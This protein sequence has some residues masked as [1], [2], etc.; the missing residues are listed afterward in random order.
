MTVE[1]LG[2][3]TASLTQAV[4]ARD[5]VGGLSLLGKANVAVSEFL[6]GLR[7]VPRGA[8]LTD[9]FEQLAIKADSLVE[10]CATVEAG[11]GEGRG[12][13]EDPEREFNPAW[14]PVIL[15]GFRAFAKLIQTIRD[16]RTN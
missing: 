5:V 7:N 15:E 13:G 9:G 8:A 11:A 4:V 1:E 16:N 14:I 3:L 10:A 6:Q 12:A 2:S